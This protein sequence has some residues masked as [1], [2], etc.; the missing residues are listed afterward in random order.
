[1]DVS[2]GWVLQGLLPLHLTLWL[3]RDVCY[4]DMGS[5]SQSVRQWWGDSSIYDK[6]YMPC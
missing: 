3:F 1:M 6:S 4:A 5:L 2:V